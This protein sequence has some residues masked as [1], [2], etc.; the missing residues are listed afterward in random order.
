M[1]RDVLLR[2]KGLQF[3]EEGTEEPVEVIAPGTYFEKNGKHYIKYE[4]VMEGFEGTVSNLIK[5]NGNSMEVTRKGIANAHLVF[6]ENKK[7][8]TCY[9]T[10][11]GNLLVGISATGIEM[12]TTEDSMDVKVDYALEVNYEH[13]ADCTI[14][15][16][17]QSKKGAHLLS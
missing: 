17:I 12:S 7:N 16:N 4:E 2:I 5:I 11:F 6:E 9:N 15:M 1:T 14:S 10:P 8:L 13:L 3:A